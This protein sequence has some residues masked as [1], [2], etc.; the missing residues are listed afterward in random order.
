MPTASVTE[1]LA[2]HRAG[3]S[4]AL[5]HAFAIVY[6]DLRRLARRELHGGATPTLNTTGLVHELYLKLADSSQVVASDRRHLLALASRAMRQIIVDYAR[7]RLTQKR[8]GGA[9]AAQVDMNDVADDHP[10]GDLLWIDDALRDLEARDER[11]VHVVECRFFAGLSEA[12]T[13]ETLDTSLSTVQRDWKRAKAWLR[14]YAR[15]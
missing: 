12:D 11:L 14:E 2:A 4:A 13:A 5:D 7:Q 6:E 10:A 8:G 15:E 1:L 9:P 3:D